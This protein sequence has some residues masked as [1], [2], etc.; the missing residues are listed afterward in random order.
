MK[1]HKYN[2]NIQNNETKLTVALCGNPNSGKTT[3][4][5]A[6]T[7]SNQK[8]GNWPGVT[9]E[10]KIGQYKND[11][12]VAI[13]DTPGIYS[14]TPFTI[15]EQVAHDYLMNGKPDL[16][17]NIIDSTNL[18]RNLFLT[19]QLLELD[20]P[21]VAALNMQDEAEAKGI[22]IDKEKLSEMLGIHFFDI[23]ASKGTGIEAL[24]TYCLDGK[25]GRK[26]PLRY[27]ADIE[28]AIPA[29][30]NAAN[31][32][33]NKRWVA[34]KMLEDDKTVNRS[35]KDQS[36][37]ARI[38]TLSQ[39]VKNSCGDIVSTAIA[40]QRYSFI[41][42][43]ISA[44]LVKKSDEKKQKAQLITDKID[45]IVL[46]K[47]LAFPIFILVMSIV[48]FVS[49]G[50]LGGWL[51][52]LINESFTPWFQEVVTGWLAPAKTPWLTSLVV[53]GIIAGVLGVVSFL[54]QIMLLFGF[55]AI[56]EASGYMSRIA[57]IM[58]RLL[59]KIGLGGKS[60]VSMILGCGCSVPAIMATRTI[61]NINERNN[62]ITLTPFMPCSAKMAIISFF[63]A[64]LLG[65]NAL[66]AI[67][68]Y[69]LSIAAVI[70]GGL[71]L[72]IFGRKKTSASDTFIM[73]LPTYRAPKPANVLK[74]M[75]ERGKSFLIKAGTIIFT[76]S[77]LLWILQ[78]FNW[79]LQFVDAQDSML[80]S[81]GTVIAP[82]FAPLGFGDW[83]FAV[84]TLT[85][86]A[87][88]ETVVTTLEIL[89]VGDITQAITPLGA[90]SFVVYNLLTVPCVAA[91][92][93]SFAEQGKKINGL[94]SALFQIITAYVVA[95]AIYQLGTLAQ[96]YTAP[97]IITLCCIIIAFALYFAIRF[98]IKKRGCNY[99]C[100][101]CPNNQNC[102]KK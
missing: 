4:F 94:K 37:A 58:D 54:P 60:F 2:K 75:W 6:L 44:C 30:I 24:M 96:K 59:S 16:V 52:D 77:V 92:S 95:L 25:Y 53:D 65:G 47:W 98:L 57:F 87:A 9:V 74:Q 1:K 14:L 51:C 79:R 48:F 26:T 28:N 90:Y 56:L 76:A 64:K 36:V 97:F 35:D 70:F 99:E 32:Q 86:I 62:T 13:V 81:I 11:K 40:T 27:T 78:S 38:S 5:N 19:T 42:K 31:I 71:I 66:F 12:S 55:I 82:I 100:D 8:V 83:R 88:K 102:T 91:I 67:S 18:E 84:A 15:D 46:N 63:T 22:Y 49:I 29:V 41:E 20:V 34:L 68:F 43:I 3:L 101:H 50:G 80:A 72:K 73:E 33:D 17:I 89:V 10:Q 69:F 39:S 45:K 21:V 93:A 23:S 7:G 61:K 85:G